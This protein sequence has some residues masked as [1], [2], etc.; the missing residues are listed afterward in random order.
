[1][2]IDSQQTI[3]F[4]S[5]IH[6]RADL[7][8]VIEKGFNIFTLCAYHRF[9]QGDKTYRWMI[10]KQ[11]FFTHMWLYRTFYV[12]YR[13]RSNFYERNP[14]SKKK[15]IYSC[16]PWLCHAQ[17]L[18]KFD[19]VSTIFVLYTPSHITRNRLRW[20]CVNDKAM[21]Y[22]IIIIMWARE[23]GRV[24]KVSTSDIF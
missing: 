21:C 10:N 13:M 7:G 3:W 1:M 17:F 9:L 19:N 20:K 12:P 2:L 22:I 5:P 6:V 18:M 23:S 15:V 11:A 8:T 4:S 24:W 14:P 16:I